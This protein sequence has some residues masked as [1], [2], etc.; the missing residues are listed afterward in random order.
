MATDDDARAAAAQEEAVVYAMTCG[1]MAVEGEIEEVRQAIAASRVRLAVLAEAKRRLAAAKAEAKA[2]AAKAKAAAA[3]AKAEAK[4][5]EQAHKTAEKAAE[6]AHK[7]A[8]KTR[9]ATEKAAETAHKAAEKTRKEEAAIQ[10]IMSKQRAGLKLTP[11]EVKKHAAHIL[12]AQEKHNEARRAFEADSCYVY[13]WRDHDI[14]GCEH[15]W[16]SIR[17]RTEVAQRLV[18]QGKARW[19][20]PANIY[21]HDA[22]AE[23]A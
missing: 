22:E 8:E 20:P 3:K 1:V 16:G 12:Q 15:H 19:T 13:I 5:A 11:A 4:E 18:A 14:G 7:E 9:K 21:E 2:A 6:T 17:V 23:D 10:A